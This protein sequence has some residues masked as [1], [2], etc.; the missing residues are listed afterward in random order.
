MIGQWAQRGGESQASVVIREVQINI[1]MRHYYLT[2]FRMAIK[3]EE[4][5][6]R[7]GGGWGEG[8]KGRREWWIG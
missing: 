3:R 6:E 4:E 7:G 5:G 2:P 1:N 8:K